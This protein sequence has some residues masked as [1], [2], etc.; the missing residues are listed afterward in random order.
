MVITQFTFLMII[1]LGAL[2]ENLL[3]NIVKSYQRHK[4]NKIQ[5]EVN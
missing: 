4:M 2:L 1:L 3:R 5:K